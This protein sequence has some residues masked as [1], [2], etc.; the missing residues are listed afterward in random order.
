MDAQRLAEIDALFAAALEIEPADRGAFLAERCGADAALRREVEALLEHSGAGVEALVDPLRAFAASLPA[1]AADELEPGTALGAWRVVAPLGRG[2]MG[3]VYLGERSDGAFAQ[4][5]AIKILPSA[6]SSAA[7]IARFELER[8]ILA[9]LSH[10]HIAHLLDGG[11]DGRGLP[12]LV[13]EH[14]EGR[15]LDAWCD[16]RRAGVDERLRLL[17]AVAR[18]VAAAH[19]NLVVHRDL[20][21]ANVLVTAEGVVKL[22][23]FGIAKLLDPGPGDLALTALEARPMT[24]A[25]ASPEQVRGEP[26]TTASD[27]YQLGLLLYELL[28]GRRP[29]QATSGSLAELVKVVCE[30]EPPPPSRA[31]VAAGGA[32]PAGELARLRQSTPARLARHYRGDLDAVVARALAKDPERRYGSAEELAADLERWLAGR[33]VRARRPTVGYRAGKFLRRHLAASLAAGLALALTLA[34]AVGVT[35][36]ARAIDAQ[37]Q[38][39]EVEAAKASEVERFLLGLFESSDP[40]VALGHEV[41][42]RELLER[43]V[44]RVG[45][46]L[47]GQPEVQARL[48]STLGE[49]HGSLDLVDA[50]RALVERALERQLRLHGER[51]PEVAESYHRLGVLQR[52]GD[53]VEAAVASL[54]RALALRRELVPSDAAELARNLADLGEAQRRSGDLEAAAASYRESLAI[55]ERRGDREGMAA[56]LSNLSALSH[57]R[58][59]YAGAEELERRALAIHLEMHGDEHPETA[60][61]RLNLGMALR[62]QGR[63]EAAIAELESA[64]AIHRAVYGAEH[65]TTAWTQV[66]LGMAFQQQGDLERAEAELADVYPRLVAKLGS[67]DARTADVA[68]GLGQLRVRQGRPAE[69]EPLLR[70]ALAALGERYGP[71]HYRLGSAALWLGRALAGSGRRAE[72]IEIWRA[73]LARMRPGIDERFVADFRAELA[74]AGQPAPEL[75]EPARAATR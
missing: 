46:D 5:G 73:G 25:F 40:G 24:P 71:E 53:D 66:E 16:E 74:A 45:R 20:K 72:A 75:E 6:A 47:A 10:P 65:F 35:L 63:V 55:H 18:A 44:A 60:M 67:D 56:G 48:E 57:S 50:G 62:R 69:A 19:R 29:Q 34:Y 61:S 4:R 51:H 30:R 12:Y 7:A 52:L 41:T 15:P 3:A 59:D 36:Q 54:E 28:T 37:R 23:D 42:A 26:I 33:P 27:V 11:V 39:A 17:V 8:R 58:R 38:R 31:V 9:R 14:V 2:G 64:F 22:L 68:V 1:A 32:R 21:P 43:G 13:L 70:A 49:I